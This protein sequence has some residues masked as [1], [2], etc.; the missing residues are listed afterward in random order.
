MSIMAIIIMKAGL[1]ILIEGII[2]S[3]ILYMD[4]IYDNQEVIK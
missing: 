3:T 1:L 4:K 2:W